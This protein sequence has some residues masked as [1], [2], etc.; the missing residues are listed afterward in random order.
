MAIYLIETMWPLNMMWQERVFSLLCEDLQIPQYDLKQR[1]STFLA[2]GT[3]FVEDDFSM[4]RG[5]G[6]W[7][8]Q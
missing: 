4:D 1:S 3:S 7:F 6:G 2:P 8:R 5:P